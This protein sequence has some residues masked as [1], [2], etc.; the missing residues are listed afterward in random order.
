[1]HQLPLVHNY[2]AIG[3]SQGFFLIVGDHDRGDAEF[4]LTPANLAPQ[5]DANPC[6]QRGDSSATGEQG[7]IKSPENQWECVVVLPR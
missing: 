6:I 4:F 2:N 7:V 5:P 3:H 1:M